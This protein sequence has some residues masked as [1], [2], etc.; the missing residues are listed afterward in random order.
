MPRIE[1]Q[2]QRETETYLNRDYEKAEE[3]EKEQ[4]LKWP[5][6]MSRHI[7]HITAYNRQIAELRP[8]CFYTT[9]FIGSKPV[10]QHPAICRL[11][12]PHPPTRSLT[13]CRKR[14]RGGRDRSRRVP[15][16]PVGLYC[17]CRPA[18]WG[19]RQ[20]SL[21][22]GNIRKDHAFLGQIERGHIP[23]GQLRRAVGWATGLLLVKVMAVVERCVQHAAVL[24]TGQPDLTS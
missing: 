8:A 18:P 15:P 19:I 11:H 23:I 3:G 20:A 22:R 9:R 10:Q 1:G 5:F 7:K 13:A 4:R 14:Y 6:M 12:S 2:Q 16:A 24:A 17:R 21:C